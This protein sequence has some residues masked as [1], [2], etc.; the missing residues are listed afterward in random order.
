MR[1]AA[2]CFVLALA[3]APAGAGAWAQGGG[4]AMDKLRACSL[5]APAERLECLDK[6]SRD[7][8]PPPSSSAASPAQRGAAGSAD[9]W[10]VSETTSPLDYSPIATATATASASGKPEGA[11]LQLSIL[12]RS[13]RTDLMIGSAALTRRGEDYL[14][15]YNIGDSPS[16]TVA[17]GTPAAGTG[18]AVK[19][20]I[21]RLLTS[22][23]GGGGDFTVHIADRLGAVA[24]DARYALAALKSVAERLAV[25][26]RWSAA[27]APPRTR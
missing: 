2:P 1:W 8:T 13:G 10:I 5:L 21:V 14:V 25:P 24:L 6:L 7:I 16:V 27:A 11:S 20:D 4:D 22:L 9:N 3:L 15:S 26:C 19:G 23:P 18:V 12:C 17:A